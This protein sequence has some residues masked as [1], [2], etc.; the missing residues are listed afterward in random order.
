[1]K[2]SA[3]EGI[4]TSTNFCPPP[5]CLTLRWQP[6]LWK[7]VRLS[8]GTPTGTRRQPTAAILFYLFLRRQSRHGSPT[9]SGVT[10]FNHVRFSSS[11]SDSPYGGTAPSFEV[12]HTSLK[13]RCRNLALELICSMSVSEITSLYLLGRNIWAGAASSPL[14]V[15]TTVGPKRVVR[16]LALR[17]RYLRFTSSSDRDNR[18]ARDPIK[19]LGEIHYGSERKASY[20]SHVR[21]K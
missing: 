6:C 1:M 16:R 17:M 11:T 21:D 14:T 12:G 15:R 2:L 10:Q 18:I 13:T 3:K 9:P 4:E 19:F 7:H 5:S 20:R 8:E